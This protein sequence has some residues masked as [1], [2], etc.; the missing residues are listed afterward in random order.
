MSRNRSNC[1]VEPRHF[2]ALLV[3]GQA[4]YRSIRSYFKNSVTRIGSSLQIRLEH[5]ASHQRPPLLGAVPPSGHESRSNKSCLRIFAMLTAIAHSSS[6]LEV[7]SVC[8]RAYPLPEPLPEPF[9]QTF[10]SFMMLICCCTMYTLTHSRCVEGKSVRS[11]SLPCAEQWPTKCSSGDS[12]FKTKVEG[13]Y[14]H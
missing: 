7:K 3:K 8:A 4:R 2:F 6:R 5:Q 11:T 1:F 9:Q 10:L 12:W 13:L 14:R